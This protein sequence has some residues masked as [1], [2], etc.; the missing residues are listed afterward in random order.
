M[1]TRVLIHMQASNAPT[2]E[3]AKTPTADGSPLDQL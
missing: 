3:S 1:C 2:L